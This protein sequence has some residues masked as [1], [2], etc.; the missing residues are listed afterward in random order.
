[1]FV[2]LKD[3]YSLSVLFITHDIAS[4][5]MISDEM[6][7]LKEGSVVDIGSPETIINNSKDKYTKQ[8]IK[9]STSKVL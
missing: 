9:A 6:V 8:L 2:R 3:Q 1:M 7:V 5:A 4:A